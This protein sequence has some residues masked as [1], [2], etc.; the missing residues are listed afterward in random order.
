MK[1][2]LQEYFSFTKKERTGIIVLLVL[3]GATV[4]F[5]Y[6]LRVPST[7]PDRAAFER[8]QQQLVQLKTAK[9]SGDEA[10]PTPDRDL[11]AES[12]EEVTVLFT[13]DPNRLPVEGWKKLGIRERTAHI[14]QH[15]LARG[16][17]FRRPEDLYK[18]YG[19]RREEADRLLPYVKIEATEQPVKER[20]VAERTTDSISYSKPPKRFEEPAIIDI[21]RADTTAFIAL[22]GIGSK[23]AQRIVHFR[24]KLGGFYAVEQVGE[25]Y[26][27]PDSTFQQIRKLLHC[28][29]PA[30]RTININ[31][32]DVTTLQQHPYIR[33]PLANAI[34]QYRQQHGVYESVD[35]L[36]K[37][38]I[39]T[40]AVLEKIRPYLTLE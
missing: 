14:I 5:P 33:W 36:L 1:N 26:G 2:Y 30:L 18:I 31:G 34:V 39:V 16:G 35:Q 23:L 19:L 17:R 38:N 8:L 28:P 24:E 9:D 25:T 27:L 29:S 21:N 6:F 32:T 3:T 4:A 37:I 7:P 13:F 11:V 10:P 20:P 15:Y 40:T 22:R 12:R